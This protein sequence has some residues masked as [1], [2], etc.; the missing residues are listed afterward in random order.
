MS[1]LLAN[2]DI[3]PVEFGPK[4]VSGDLRQKL[5]SA[6][7]YALLSMICYGAIVETVHSHGFSRPD[8]SGFTSVSDASESQSTSGIY[9]HQRDC[10]ICQF[11]RQLFDGFHQTTLL[12]ST[13]LT[14][15]AFVFSQPVTYICTSATRFSG[16]APPLAS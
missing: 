13:N 14:E 7:V 15:I 4:A 9:T 5:R 10:S 3:G 8:R 1:G 11:Q 16:R 2:P 12:V 6:V